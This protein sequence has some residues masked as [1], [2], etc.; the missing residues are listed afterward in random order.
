[1]E[2]VRGQTTSQQ[3]RFTAKVVFRRQKTRSFWNYTQTSSRFE[4]SAFRNL[5]KLT[6][7]LFT[8]APINAHTDMS[9][10]DWSVSLR[11]TEFMFQR[12]HTSLHL[13]SANTHDWMSNYPGV[14]RATRNTGQRLWK[15]AGFYNQVCC[16]KSDFIN[17]SCKNSKALQLLF[18]SC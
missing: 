10:Q 11:W 17:L 9:R 2:R 6:Q 5:Q 3:Q 13:T 7:G 4:G 1:M 16:S 8:S 15:Y 14:L 12:G 18:T